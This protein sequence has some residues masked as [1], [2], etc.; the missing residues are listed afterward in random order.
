MDTFDVR[1]H[2]MDGP[3]KWCL[4]PRVPS[5]ESWDCPAVVRSSLGGVFFSRR[6]HQEKM[7]NKNG[8]IVVNS[9]LIVGL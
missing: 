3:R 2:D 8:L 6:V 7:G 9:W 4:N 1:G 5:A